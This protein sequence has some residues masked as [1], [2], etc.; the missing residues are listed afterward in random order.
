M[1]KPHGRAGQVAGMVR[2]GEAWRTAKTAETHGVARRERAMGVGA[3]V[4]EA[5]LAT[6]THAGRAGG[7]ALLQG[8]CEPGRAWQD[9]AVAGRAGLV[10]RAPGRRS[11]GAGGREQRGRAAACEAAIARAEAEIERHRDAEALAELDAARGAAA[12]GGRRPAGAPAARWPGDGRCR[13]WAAWTRRSSS[14]GRPGRLRS[15]AGSSDA[16]ALALYRIGVVRYKMGSLATAASL[17]DE[18]LRACE[19]HAA[20]RPTR[21]GR[22]SS[23]PA[24][25]SA[26]ARRT[27]RRRPRM[28]SRRWSWRTR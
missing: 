26:A 25:R 19:T 22:A 4:R 6:G 23:T 24:P 21:C 1:R 5:R 7:L 18:A 8:V 20:I 2:Y 28:S 17:L 12:P 14:W 3:R 13:T 11:A 9:A 27:S 10:R 16:V 15:R